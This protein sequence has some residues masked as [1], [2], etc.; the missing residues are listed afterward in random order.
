MKILGAL[1]ALFLC[2]GDANAEIN[3]EVGPAFL[4]GEFS[5]GGLLIIS[6]RVTPKWSIG[7]AY[8]SEQVCNRRQRLVHNY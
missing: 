8:I 6:D 7:L 2:L 3:I 5:D 4:S 1:V